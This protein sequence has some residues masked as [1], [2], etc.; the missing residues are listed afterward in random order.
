MVL[1]LYYCADRSAGESQVNNTNWVF[2]TLLLFYC[3]TVGM[4]VCR[5][6]WRRETDERYKLRDG[7]LSRRPRST[8]AILSGKS[9]L[10]CWFYYFTTGFTTADR[11]ASIRPLVLQW[12][13]PV[14][15]ALYA[16]VCWRI[17]TY[18]DV[19]WRM[20]TYANVCWR[21][22][23]YGCISRLALSWIRSAD[24]SL[25]TASTSTAD[26]SNALTAA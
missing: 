21:M 14:D 18:D 12:I 19:C 25:L 17:L 20:L 7:V 11:S 3:F 10:Y 13:R 22:L 5:Q 24:I 23:T 4:C 6:K 26:I 1:L 9:P 15:L 16:D 2:S 8:C